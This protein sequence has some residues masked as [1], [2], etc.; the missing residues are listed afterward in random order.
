MTGF[1]SPTAAFQVHRAVRSTGPHCY[2]PAPQVCGTLLAAQGADSVQPRLLEGASYPQ[3]CRQLPAGAAQQCLQQLSELLFEILASYQLMA[4]FHEA[5]QQA[6]VEQQR[7]QQA[8]SGGEG[9]GGEGAHMEQVQ[10]ATRA[11]L[12]AVAGALEEG[13]AE[14]VDAAAAKL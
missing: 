10:A 3:L 2:H 6:H 5:N 11:L 13:R 9:G 7:Q 12:Q 1:R 4:E 8:A 14:V